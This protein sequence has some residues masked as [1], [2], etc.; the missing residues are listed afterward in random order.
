MLNSLNSLVSMFSSLIEYIQQA[1]CRDGDGADN[2]VKLR[3]FA[4]G[5]E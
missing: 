4:K 5:M 1:S 3:V 2:D